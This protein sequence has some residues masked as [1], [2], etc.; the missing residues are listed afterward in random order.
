MPAPDASERD[1]LRRHAISRHNQA[2]VDATV[3]YIL[4]CIGDM[5][6][7]PHTIQYL[8][9][10]CGIASAYNYKITDDFMSYRHQRWFWSLAEDGKQLAVEGDVPEDIRSWIMTRPDSDST[11]IPESESFHEGISAIEVEVEPMA[12]TDE[13]LL[14]CDGADF[15]IG[16]VDEEIEILVAPGLGSVRGSMSDEVMDRL[17][18]VNGDIYLRCPNIPVLVCFQEAAEGTM[19]ELLDDLDGDDGILDDTATEKRWSAWIFQIVASLTVFQKYVRFCHN[20]LHTNNIVWVST[21]EEFIYYKSETGDYYKVPTYGKIF[22]LIDFGR[23]TCEIGDK[24]IMSSDFA[25]GQD[26]A[27]QYNWGPFYNEGLP[28]VKP[29]MSFDLCRLAVSLFDSL[30]PD[31]DSRQDS[32]LAK[33]LW[34][35]MTDDEGQSILFDSDGDERFPGFELYIHIAAAVHGAVPAEQFSA[36]A[37]SQF[38]WKGKDARLNASKVHTYPI[39]TFAEG[40][41]FDI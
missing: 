30:C 38:R 33:L 15:E 28:T 19:D 10:V 31:E 5:G 8:E 18:S 22:K 40:T 12:A 35:W 3:C 1:E 25:P 14:E 11:D 7:S 27:G 21:K 24:M 13:E 20:D 16:S 26:A 36:K 2:S 4:S 32:E 37:L 6:L 41:V 29:N 39:F 9:T 17:E 23:A 34:K